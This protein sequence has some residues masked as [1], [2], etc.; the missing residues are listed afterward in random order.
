MEVEGWLELL[1]AVA[2]EAG[3]KVGGVAKKGHEGRS[4]EVRRG[5]IQYPTTNSVVQ[6]RL[7][8]LRPLCLLALWGFRVYIYI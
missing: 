8:P 7:V 6:G 2:A 3:C 4:F 5:A 1:S